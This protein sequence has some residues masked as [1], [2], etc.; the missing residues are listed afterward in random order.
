MLY[1]EISIS[2]QFHILFLSGLLPN[3]M[4]IM[5]ITSSVL[6]SDQSL[7][8]ET[9]IHVCKNLCSMCADLNKFTTICFPCLKIMLPE[10]NVSPLLPNRVSHLFL[11][12]DFTYNGC[13]G[14][15]CPFNSILP[16]FIWHIFSSLLLSPNVYL[17]T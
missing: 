16:I 6:E 7:I 13:T 3:S 2:S 17:L 15:F 10:F 12:I 5:L 9:N 4:L 11:V 14:K 1:I 8:Y